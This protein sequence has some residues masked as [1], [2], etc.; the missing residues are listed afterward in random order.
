MKTI[1]IYIVDDHKLFVEGISALMSDEPDLEVTGYSLSGKDYL[2]KASTV[3]A[4]V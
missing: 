4:D 2:E 3:Q 1:H